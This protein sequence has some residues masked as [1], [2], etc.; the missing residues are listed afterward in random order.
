MERSRA[1]VSMDDTVCRRLAARLLGGEGVAVAHAYR[2][3]LP[4]IRALAHGRLGCAALL[5]VPPGSFDGTF[6]GD[7]PLPV[8]LHIARLADSP[9]WRIAMADVYALGSARV[10]PD[11]EGARLA[12]MLGG[13]FAVAVEAGLA[14]VARVDVESVVLH[15][16][17]G[18]RRLEAAV[19]GCPGPWDGLEAAGEALSVGSRWFGE[20]ADAVES[21][22][23]AGFRRISQSAG[24]RPPALDGKLV[25]VDVCPEGLLLLD[26]R[27]GIAFTTFVAFDAP[28]GDAADI[29]MLL[30]RLLH[31]TLPI[32]V[33]PRT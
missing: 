5:A 21:G 15:G 28:A 30:S 9:G 6:Q 7:A 13:V 14:V 33:P 25:L 29:G 12:R 17:V 1:A 2:S 19:L 8:R 3:A 27:E 32:A 16:P 24:P 4:P 26:L 20:L 23:I 18:V 31:R 11:A 22:R 10:A